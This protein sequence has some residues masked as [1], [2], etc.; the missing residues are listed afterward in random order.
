M[1]KTRIV[2]A[3]VALAVLVV[4]LFAVPARIAEFAIAVVTLSGAWEWSAL[5]R[6]QTALTRALYVTAVAALL[7]LAYV[8]MGPLLFVVL[9]LALVWW[10]AAML[11][12]MVFPTPVPKTVAWIGGIMV[13]VPLFVALVALYRLG[14]E[15]LLFVLGVVWAADIGAFFAGKQFGKVKLKPSISPG[16]TWEGVIG[17]LIAVALLSTAGSY[18]FDER[19]A[20]LLPFCL[21]VACLSI[22]GDLTVSIFKR[23][24]S[25]KDSGT[26]FPGHGG[27]LDRVDSIA[28]ASPIFVLGIARLGVL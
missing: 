11:W 27:V 8:Y 12:V 4:I 6:L 5:L 19:L 14:P 28:A 1:L 22:V 7:A 23:N 25:V 10:L 16:K 24:A 13:L 18:L 9:F 17:G 3:I 15:Y 21:A 2:T 20:Q 26:L